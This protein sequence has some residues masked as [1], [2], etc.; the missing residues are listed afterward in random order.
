MSSTDLIDKIRAQKWNKHKGIFVLDISTS[1]FI[2]NWFDILFCRNTLSNRDL[3]EYIIPLT[4]K[5]VMLLFMTRKKS[6]WFWLLKYIK[7]K[8]NEIK[9]QKDSFIQY[10]NNNSREETRIFKPNKRKKRKDHGIKEEK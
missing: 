9:K 10:R 3:F 6:D 7:H 5:L 8:Y 4:K 1:I 2:F